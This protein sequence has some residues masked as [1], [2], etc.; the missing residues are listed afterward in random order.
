MTSHRDADAK[1]ASRKIAGELRAELARQQRTQAELA[2]VLGMTPHTVGRRLT[3]YTDFTAVE[4]LQAA[5][6]LGVSLSQLTGESAVS[7]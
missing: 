4:L 5:A 1:A 6:W 3:G 7:A 2:V